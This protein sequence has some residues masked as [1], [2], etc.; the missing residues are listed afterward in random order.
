M[1]KPGDVIENPRTGERIVFRQTAAET[2]GELLEMDFFVAPGGFAPR[3]HI[4]GDV[5][6]RFVAVSGALTLWVDGK[7][8]R[9]APGEAAVAPAGSGHTFRAEGQEMAHF[10]AEIRPAL[11]METLFETVFGLFRDGK[12]NRKGW[13]NLLQGVVLA[14]EYRAFLAGPPTALQRPLIAA[15][16]GVGRLLG[17]RARYEKY[18]G[19]AARVDN[20][21]RR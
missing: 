8:T 9:L 17:Y 1:A 21:Q 12:T 6:E 20:T 13:E 16:A 18:S 10:I 2:G 4:H 11:E 15:L 5:E 14:H 3:R 19:G 7:E